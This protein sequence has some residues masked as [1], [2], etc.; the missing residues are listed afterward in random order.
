MLYHREIAPSSAADALAVEQALSFCQSLA[1]KSPLPMFLRVQFQL[2]LNNPWDLLQSSTHAWSAWYDGHSQECGLA[3]GSSHELKL[4][5]DTP[6]KIA[7]IK[8]SGLR[9]H[10]IS[11]SP[12]NSVIALP[13]SMGGFSFEA[14][15][16]SMSGPWSAWSRNRIFVP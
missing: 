16:S 6:Y 14:S 9:E 10:S 3:L 7:R 13:L 12:E 15:H 2:A 8:S 4:D 11:L 5:S 1:K